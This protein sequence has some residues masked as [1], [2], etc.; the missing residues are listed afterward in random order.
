LFVMH[1]GGFR[2]LTVVEDGKPVGIVS[3]RSALDPER[4]SSP[5][6]RAAGSISSGCGAGDGGGAGRAAFD[7]KRNFNRSE[8][9][10]TKQTDLHRLWFGR[11][12][13]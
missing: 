11:L 10:A 4:R 1:Q 6:R 12:H 8:F 3:A 5:R 7:P 2:H 13:L 9:P